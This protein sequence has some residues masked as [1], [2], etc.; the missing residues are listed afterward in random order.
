MAKAA[1]YKILR[2][3]AGESP[4]EIGVHP[5]QSKRIIVIYAG[6][7][8]DVDGKFNKY[9]KIARNLVKRGAGAVVHASDPRGSIDD[10]RLVLKYVKKHARDI[11]GCDDPEIYLGGHS[12]GADTAAQV[13]EEYGVKRLLLIGATKTSSTLRNF[14][15]KVFV[16]I[17]ARDAYGL[18]ASK[19]HYKEAVNAESREL[20]IVP[21]AEHGFH[22][23][24]SHRTYHKAYYWAFADDVGY[25]KFRTRRAETLA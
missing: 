16:T 24:I 8:T 20:V 22:G 10:L 9:P 21:R 11:C 1:S 13:A 6:H 7:G 4:L 5:L 2:G 19:S 17:G 3:S 25:P 12:A 15:G 18:S 23:P 14:K